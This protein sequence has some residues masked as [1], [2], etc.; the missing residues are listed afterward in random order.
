MTVLIFRIQ[1]DAEQRRAYLVLCRQLLCL[2]VEK[3]GRRREILKI[4]LIPARE[5]PKPS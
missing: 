2:D 5:V 4:I 3:S 1:V